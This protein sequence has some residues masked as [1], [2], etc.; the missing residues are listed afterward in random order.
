MVWVV[1]YIPKYTFS[2]RIAHYNAHVNQDSLGDFHPVLR[3]GI[4]EVSIMITQDVKV[5]F[6]AGFERSAW[7]SVFSNFGYAALER[8]PIR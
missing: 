1:Q 3:T 7:Y 8:G 4:N 2:I 5:V 6:G